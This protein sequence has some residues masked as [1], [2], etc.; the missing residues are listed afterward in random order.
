M[1]TF[2]ILCVFG[3]VACGGGAGV[4]AARVGVTQDGGG[5]CLLP[6]VGQVVDVKTFDDAGAFVAETT[7]TYGDVCQA[8]AGR[9]RN[10]I[11]F[12]GELCCCPVV[13]GVLP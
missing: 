10:C 6:S 9:A 12:D 2:A 5:S 7:V 8:D 13:A 4:A 11:P 1:R 3:L